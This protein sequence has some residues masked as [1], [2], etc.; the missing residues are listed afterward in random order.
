MNYNFPSDRPGF[1]ERQQIHKAIQDMKL[2]EIK[3]KVVDP[4]AQEYTFKPKLS[5]MAKNIK[6][7][8]NDL[9]VKYII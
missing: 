3:S 6:R 4:D 1:L 8:V 5:H 9:Y 2:E 7:S